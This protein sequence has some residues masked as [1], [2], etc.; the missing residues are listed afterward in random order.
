[1]FTSRI[2]QVRVPPLWPFLVRAFI[3]LQIPGV[4]ISTSRV[5]NWLILKF[6]LAAQTKL[7]LKH[8]QVS[9]TPKMIHDN[10]FTA[11]NSAPPLLNAIPKEFKRS[12]ISERCVKAKVSLGNQLQN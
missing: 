4:K 9:L 10:L 6:W 11:T 1:M 3:S 2:F 12:L 5:V 8:Q 7:T